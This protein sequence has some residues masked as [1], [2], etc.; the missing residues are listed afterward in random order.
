[1]KFI[2][3]CLITIFAALILIV[4]PIF[5]QSQKY[6]FPQASEGQINEAIA[7]IVP[8]RWLPSHPLYFL[9]TAKET[10]SRILQSSSANRA[11]FDFV[12]SGKRLKEVY[13]LLDR[14]DVKSANKTLLRYSSRLAAMDTQLEKARSQNQDIAEIVAEMAEGFKNQEVLLF[15]IS[16]KGSADDSNFDNSL[17]TAQSSFIKAVFEINNVR[18]GV[19]DRFKTVTDKEKVEA[20]QSAVPTPADNTTFIQASPSARP[21]RIIY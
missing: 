7:K 8:V 3:V 9:I 20:S 12:L 5:A 19:K 17:S 4:S 6:Y 16:K 13:L 15:A 18:P 11:Q 2:S 14:G 21:R 1:M 10:I